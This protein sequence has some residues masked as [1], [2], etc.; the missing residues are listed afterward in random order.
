MLRQA[1]DGRQRNLGPDHP[2]CFESMH[3]LAALYKE[4]SRYDEAETLLLKALE[5]RRMK[6]GDK[7]PHTLQ[8]LNNLIEL[9]EA[10]GKPE[11]IKEWWG[12]LPQ[13]ENIRK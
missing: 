7:H 4:Q 2:A 12:K 5:G 11:K 3:E 13:A 1:L 10:W 8:S 6:L 9:Y